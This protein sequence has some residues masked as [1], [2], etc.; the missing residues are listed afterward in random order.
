M[1]DFMY[2][3]DYDDALTEAEGKLDSAG[4]PTSRLGKRDTQDPKWDT[5]FN[6]IKVYAIVKCQQIR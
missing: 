1:I 2:K 3:A 6:D 5:I 4:E